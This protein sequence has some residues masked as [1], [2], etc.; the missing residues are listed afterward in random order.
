MEDKRENARKENMIILL[1]V[2]VLITALSITIYTM[3]RGTAEC[4]REMIPQS[5]FL[6]FIV[7]LSITLGGIITHALRSKERASVDYI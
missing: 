2:I 3:G 4:T 7:V 5:L 6:A 1:L